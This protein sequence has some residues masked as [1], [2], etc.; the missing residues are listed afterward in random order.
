M[1]TTGTK[2][3]LQC[4]GLMHAWRE[5]LQLSA[6]QHTWLNWKN[7]W[8]HQAN[9]AVDDAQWSSQ[10]IT[11]LDKLA[12]AAVQKNDTVEHLVLANKLLMDTVAKLQ[13]DN[14]KLLT[15]I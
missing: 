15:I 5:W 1:V 14:A 12:N 10:L 7:H 2:H 11:S 9:S 4:G 6:V 8:I 13:E 3:T